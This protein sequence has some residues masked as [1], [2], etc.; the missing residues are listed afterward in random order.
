MLNFHFHSAKSTFLRLIPIWARVWLSLS[1]ELRA[2]A[3]K[4][5]TIH[6]HF[7]LNAIKRDP[8]IWC[9]KEEKIQ[10]LS[11]GALRRSAQPPSVE[12][13]RRKKELTME[14]EIIVCIFPLLRSCPLLVCCFIT[15]SFESRFCIVIRHS[16]SIRHGMPMLVMYRTCFN[17]H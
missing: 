13:W 11:C 5:L 8:H 16:T 4:P 3:E 2:T 9:K 17:R 7:T 14:I 10:H 1:S 6:T 15:F 12:V